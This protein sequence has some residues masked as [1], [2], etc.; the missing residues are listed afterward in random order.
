MTQFNLGLIGDNIRASQAPALHR[1][2]GKLVGLDVRYELFTPSEMGMNFKQSFAHVQDIG[3]TGINVT[4]PY[5]ARV[6][7]ELCID[8]PDIAQ[9]MAINTVT[10]T[11][12]GPKGYNTDFSGFISAW[13]GRF[14]K[15]QPGRVGM[16]GAGGVGKAVAFGL[17]HL[18]AEEI[19]LIDLDTAKAEA[20]AVALNKDR[21]GRA[22]AR[23]GMFNEL[24]LADGI[25]NCTPLG[26]VG[27]GGT[28]VPEGAF[29]AVNWVFDAI[30]TPVNTQF[31]A[32]AEA[33][34]AAFL[35]GYELFYW[36]GVRA[37]E[38]FTGIRIKDHATL[39]QMLARE[40]KPDE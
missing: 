24:S 35:S 39:R 9:I 26:M 29:P 27:Y 37:F 21:Q 33:A 17:K 15:R 16:F 22:F 25:V 12:G 30:Y 10:F 1:L 4:L 34:G 7:S 14:G 28:P 32:Q 18:G 20:L 5:K 3:L 23:V 6:I 38:I 36:Q 40:G 19:I 8:D 13:R 11:P 31:R 2:C